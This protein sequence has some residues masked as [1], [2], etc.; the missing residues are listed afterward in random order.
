MSVSHYNADFLAAATRANNPNTRTARSRP[1]K[2]RHLHAEMARKYQPEG[3]ALEIVGT[4]RDNVLAWEDAVEVVGWRAGLAAARRLR[5]EG[6]RFVWVFDLEYSRA[7]D[8][9]HRPEDGD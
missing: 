9:Q 7:R 1:S 3:Q 2:L 6:C 8:A 5:A 4:M